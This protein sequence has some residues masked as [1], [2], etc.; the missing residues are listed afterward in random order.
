VLRA[1]PEAEPVL[2]N[3]IAAAG[4]LAAYA[5]GRP[6]AV[7][8][9]GRGAVYAVPAPVAS[10]GPAGQWVIR[11]YH[12]GGLPGRVLGDRYLRLGRPRPFR[13]FDLARALEDR[14]AP[15]ARVV[16][17]AVYT[18]GLIYRGDL[19]TE[20]AIGTT[21]LAAVL[22]GLDRFPAGP[23]PVPVSVGDPRDP[24]AVP[25]M[26]AAGRLVRRLHDA[27]LQHPD[28]NLKNILV[29]GT[30]GTGPDALVIDLDRGRIVRSVS[31]RARRRML[32]RFWR[33]VAK[34]ERRT[35]R[36]LEPAT[37]SAFEEAY[38]AGPG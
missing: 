37:R 1:R 5:A 36:T 29:R 21:D 26:A 4:S 30:G 14:D 32:D 11:H 31:G 15:T 10:V 23:G 24:G 27:G 34:W 20:R 22:F 35:G 28:L 7:T 16:G 38:A 6:D 18:A 8:L 12:R 2:A 19:V 3:W 9:R 17:A 33:S 13:E 25:A